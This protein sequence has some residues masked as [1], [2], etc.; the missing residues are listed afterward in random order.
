M[1]AL[2]GTGQ[3]LRLAIRRDRILLPVWIVVFAGTAAVSAAATVGLY[4]TVESRVA[5][6]EAANGTASL[7]AIYGRIYDPTSLGALSMLKMSVLGAA[8]VSVLMIIVTVRHTR[9]EEE[10]GRL[11]LL[12]STVVGR[13][14]PLSAALLLSCG[15]SIALGLFTGAGLMTAGLPISGSLA[16]GMGWACV[17]F[18]FSA[19]AGVAAQLARTARA[20]IGL[21][22]AVLG[23]T[24]LMRAVADSG[25]S[26]GLTWLS[27]PSPLGLGQQVRPFAGDRWWVLLI[28][29]A[30]ALALTVVA[31]ALAST[32]DLGAG[33]LADSPGPA[34]AGVGLSGAIGLA[35]HL[36]R[37]ALLA[38][39]GGFVVLGAVLGNVASNAS[40]MLESDQARDMIARLGGG[41]SLTDAFLATE[42]GFAGFLAAAYGMQASLRLRSEETSLH[43]EALLATATTR[44]RWALSHITVAAAGTAVL[45]LAGG[46]AA[47]LAHAAQTGQPSQFG[48]VLLAA[49]VQIPAALILVAVV[50]LLFGLVPRLVHGGWIVLIA[51]LLVAELGPL[52]RLDPIIMDVSPFAHV[53]KLPGGDVTA[54]PLIVLATLAALLTIVGLAGFRRR[55]VG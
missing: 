28:L 26:D 34:K 23:A 38:W 44:L 4:P 10:T 29:L 32:R 3:L 12:G 19:V 24:Y 47:G 54:S 20:A 16:F 11:E 33:I 22:V 25:G 1:R 9:A 45:L 36:Q 21:S 13:Y 42:M 49:A 53:P 48:R 46:A 39:L 43:A 37:G 30:V 5:T 6:A 17:G 31:F 27:W 35:W 52:L 40:T 15:V 51:F 41:G 50:V 55:D 14:A 7:V 8:M 18:A 2:T